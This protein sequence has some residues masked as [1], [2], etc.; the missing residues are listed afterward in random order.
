MHSCYTRDNSIKRVNF[1]A[2]QEVDRTTRC[3]DMAIWNFSKIMAAAILDLLE[4]EIAPFYSPSPKTL[5]WNQTWSGSDDRL[6]RYGHLKFWKWEVSRRSVSCWSFVRQYIHKCKKTLKLIVRIMWW[7]H[8]TE[9]AKI[10]WVTLDVATHGASRRCPMH[11]YMYGYLKDFC[12]FSGVI[13]SH[14]P[15]NEFF[16]FIFVVL[17]PRVGECV[18]VSN[19]FL[20]WLC[21]GK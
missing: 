4:P 3:G 8:S 9:T 14:R 20:H 10:F 17:P 13:P 18:R 19:V 7:Y 12:C 1:K 11:S 2:R 15:Y 6:R 16:T 21:D 5:P